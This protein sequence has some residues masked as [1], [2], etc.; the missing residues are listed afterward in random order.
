MKKTKQHAVL[1]YRVN[2]ILFSYREVGGLE[3]RKLYTVYLSKNTVNLS[4]QI[5]ICFPFQG[6][7]EK[8]S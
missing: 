7:N 1:T 3:R 2:G 6:Q 4:A 8:Q 5:S